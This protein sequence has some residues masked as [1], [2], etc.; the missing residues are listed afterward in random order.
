MWP[1][2]KLWR[3]CSTEMWY[4][5]TGLDVCWWF[6][7]VFI[8]FR[9]VWLDFAETGTD[10][11]YWNRNQLPRITESTGFQFVLTQFNPFRTRFTKFDTVH[12]FSFCYHNWNLFGFWR[13][14]NWNQLHGIT[15]FTGFQ[16]VFLPSSIIFRTRFTK[17]DA[18][19]SFSF[20]YHITTENNISS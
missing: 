7:Q 12:S 19:Y 15:E 4:S 17:F 6:Y 20:Y 5:L 11:D 18:V 3:V 1:P 9:R 16:F 10:L 8:G 2:S 13:L 14:L